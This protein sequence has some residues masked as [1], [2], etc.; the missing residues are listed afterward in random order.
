MAGYCSPLPANRPAFPLEGCNYN[1]PQ[2]L[3]YDWYTQGSASAKADRQAHC[4]SGCS[5]SGL[6]CIHR[7]QNHHC[8]SIRPVPYSALVFH[9]HRSPC[10]TGTEIALRV[11]VAVGY[12]ICLPRFRSYILVPKSQRPC[13]ARPFRSERGNRSTGSSHRH[14]IEPLWSFGRRESTKDRDVLDIVFIWDEN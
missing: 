1:N 11:P 2:R 13:D 10:P 3:Q 7:F 8:V 12:R 6:N 9:R 5:S 4:K 14:S